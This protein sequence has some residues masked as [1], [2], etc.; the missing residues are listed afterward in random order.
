MPL[1]IAQWNDGIDR[2]CDQL[3]TNQNTLL[4]TMYLNEGNIHE[5]TKIETKLEFFEQRLNQYKREIA[6]VSAQL[7]E[8]Y[9]SSPFPSSE[10]DQKLQQ[11]A[12]TFGSAD[13]ILS[14][15]S[16]WP[17]IIMA[18]AFMVCL[19]LS[20]IFH[21]FSSQSAWLNKVLSRLDYGGISFAI[22]GGNMPVI[23]YGLACEPTHGLRYGTIALMSVLCLGAF[24]TTLLDRFEQPKYRPIRA[25][26]FIGAGLSSIVTYLI[27]LCK[28]T[29]NKMQF[30]M[31]YYSL[32]GY[33]IIQGAI[34]YAVRVPERC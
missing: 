22:L 15:I 25:G 10:L 27:V 20:T 17:L 32:A 34:L 5:S 26:L 29:V 12:P 19:A 4:T 14:Y 21:L 30:S 33:I 11:L 3:M 23:F 6:D 9:Q 2:F 24:I 31:V 8:E 7:L 28:P 13:Y 18:A 1:A 16:L